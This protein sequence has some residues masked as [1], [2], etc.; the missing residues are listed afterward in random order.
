MS[1]TDQ[2]I[3]NTLTSLTKTVEQLAAGQKA[4]EAGQ[5]EILATQQE[6]GKQ[7]ETLTLKVEVIN[8]NQQRAERQSQ[9]DHQEIMGHL[10]TV[11]DEMGKDH[12]AYEKRVDRIE[13]HLNLPPAK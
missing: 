1:D 11:A 9:R 7:L 3:L 4:L 13:K 12:K 5:Q 2:K 6:Q 8:A 10:L